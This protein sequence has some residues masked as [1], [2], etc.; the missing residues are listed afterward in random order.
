ML[1]SVGKPRVWER[2]VPV[3]CVLAYSGVLLAGTLEVD[4]LNLDDG[5]E[6][7]LSCSK[8]PQKHNLCMHAYP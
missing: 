8:R 1:A 2:P 6:D 3:A 4:V 7:V 5:E